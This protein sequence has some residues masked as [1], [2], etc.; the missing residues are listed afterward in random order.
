[1]RILS[2]LFGLFFGVFIIG[3]STSYAQ[4][5]KE[6]CNDKGKSKIRI[7]DY[8]GAMQYFEFGLLDDPESATLYNNI[9]N[10]YYIKNYQLKAQQHYTR[11]IALDQNNANLYYNRALSYIAVEKYS[12]AI[13]DLKKT[14][15][16]EDSNH[17]AIAQLANCYLQTSKYE[18]AYLLINRAIALSNKNYSYFEIRS[19]CVQKINNELISA[20]ED[21]DKAI[22]L[23]PDRAELFKKRGT[24]RE[25]TGDA[26]GSKSD[27]K[28]AKSLSKMGLLIAEENLQI[29]FL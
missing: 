4:L 21:L 7:G 17:E 28:K 19:E 11:A 25:Q 16:L 5:T 1:M 27:F 26:D 12:D 8:Q 20:L 6:Q 14:V 29:V 23:A 22:A 10:I 13:S 18:Q 24:I 2:A 3:L 9:A 15:S